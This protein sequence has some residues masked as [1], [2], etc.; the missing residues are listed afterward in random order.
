MNEALSQPEWRKEFQG[1]S[2][3]PLCPAVYD[4]LIDKPTQMKSI[5][6]VNIFKFINT[7]Q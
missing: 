5:F 3:S 6:L 2:Q 1:V 7:E 4:A